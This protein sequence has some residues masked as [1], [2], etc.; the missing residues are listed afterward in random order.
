MELKKVTLQKAKNGNGK[1]E[2]KF[3]DKS[4]ISVIKHLPYS[5]RGSLADL[6]ETKGKKVMNVSI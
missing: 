4:T 5:Q 1:T 3:T 2:I 6:Q